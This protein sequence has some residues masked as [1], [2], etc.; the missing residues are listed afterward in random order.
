[1]KKMMQF[2]RTYSYTL[3]MPGTTLY[4]ILIILPVFFT[5]FYS[6]RNWDLFHSNYIGLENYKNLL[7]S[8]SL[9]IAFKNTILFTVVTTFFKVSCGL[10]LAILLNN[11]LRSTNVIRSI[12]FL[13]AVLSQVA[14]GIIFSALMHPEIGLINVFF[15]Q[16][17]LD[18]LTQ[19]WLTNSNLAIYSI[20][21]V[22]IWQ[23]TGFGMVIFLSGLQSISSEYYEAASI[24]GATQWQQFKNITFPL[25][26]PSINNVVVISTIGGLGVF[27]LVSVLT[28]GGPGDAT[29]VFGTVIF[30]SFGA[31]LQGEACAASVILSI[32][33]CLISIPTYK[34]FRTKEVEV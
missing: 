28:G 2:N 32:L 11:K 24:D 12:F 4:I 1:M 25:L 8:A 34:F 16:I 33:V 14:V 15:R 19:D 30:R 22:E 23:W 26:M 13:P 10:L 20:C 5:I 31:N 18:F 3:L 21:L 9:N 27:G 7:T 29:Q 6:F 17:G